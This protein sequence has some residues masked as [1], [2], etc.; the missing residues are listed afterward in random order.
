MKS[1]TTHLWQYPSIPFAFPNIGTPNHE[2]EHLI[3]YPT[4]T[5][6]ALRLPWSQK[7]CELLKIQYKPKKESEKKQRALMKKKAEV[8]ICLGV[9]NF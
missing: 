1:E 4:K 5:T 7:Q 6:E 9:F 8:Q 2:G 3:T